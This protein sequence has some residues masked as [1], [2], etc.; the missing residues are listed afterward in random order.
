MLCVGYRISRLLRLH[1]YLPVEF[2]NAR[3]VAKKRDTSPNKKMAKP[4]VVDMDV[5][6]KDAMDASPQS[7]DASL[8]VNN[9]NNSIMSPSPMSHREL[10][11][12]EAFTLNTED[13]TVEMR[14]GK[15]SNQLT[16]QKWEEIVSILKFW[17]PQ[18]SNGRYLKIEEI[19]DAEEQKRVLEHRKTHPK[20]YDFVKDYA[21]EMYS[22]ADT[23]E[24]NYRLRRICKTGNNR[25]A[26]PMHQVFD[27]IR[28][29]HIETEHSGRDITYG[30]LSENFY[31]I[32]Q[33][34]VSIFIKHCPDC[35]GGTKKR[36]RKARRSIESLNFRG[37]RKKKL[38][39]AKQPTK[40][41]KFRDGFQ[42][43]LIDMRCNPQED[44][45]GITMK[46]ILTCRDQSTGYTGLFEKTTSKLNLSR[47]TLIHLSRRSHSS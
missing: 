16:P 38:A 13:L 47:Q 22:D 8:P 32:S 26:V 36:G 2:K 9:S 1:R 20:G 27:I 23:K 29:A 15:T 19:P 41:L 25:I 14:P 12:K 31:N 17:G 28:E 43:D 3:R 21:V 42:V 46:W 6:Q 39:V 30:D 37:G 5:Q 11:N 33:S 35:I 24:K 7:A 18:D 40:L 4:V 45:H 44:I 34:T 10:F